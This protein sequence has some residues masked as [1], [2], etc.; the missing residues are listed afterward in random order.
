MK[1][2]IIA[3]VAV[4]SLL[5]PALTVSA[6]ASAATFGGDECSA[7]HPIVN[8]EGA[9]LQVTSS[10]TVI[11]TKSGQEQLWCKNSNSTGATFEEYE[12]VECLQVS[13]GES[14]VGPCFNAI[15]GWQLT[16]S[17]YDNSGFDDFLLENEVTKNCLYQDGL[18]NQLVSMACQ[19]KAGVTGDVWQV[20]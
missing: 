10:N 1:R 19:N 6:P 14:V 18:N 9:W 12:G 4:A 20:S 13:G 5:T 16:P 2:I 7:R 17:V 8:I 15:A 11:A 3:A